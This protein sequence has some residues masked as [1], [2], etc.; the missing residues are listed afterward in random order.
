MYLIYS[1]TPSYC[2]H[3][4]ASVQNRLLYEH[5]LFFLPHLAALVWRSSDLHGVLRLLNILYD[6]RWQHSYGGHVL[7][8][9]FSMYTTYSLSSLSALV[10]RS[11]ALRG[12]LY[13]HNVLCDPRWQ[14]RSGGQ[15]RNLDYS[16]SE[17]V[18]SPLAQSDYGLI[19]CTA[20]NRNRTNSR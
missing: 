4:L 14:H 6:P 1:M 16:G 9:D 12:V 17:L 10:W 3:D 2:T 13:V 20:E 8:I 19:L 11:C 15:V 7:K 5:S 18:Y